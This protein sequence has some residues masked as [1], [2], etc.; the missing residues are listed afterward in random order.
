MLNFL[1]NEILDLFCS[2]EDRAIW[3]T[4]RDMLFRYGCQSEELISS[5]LWKT[6]NRKENNTRKRKP[7]GLNDFNYNRR[8]LCK[9]S[10]IIICFVLTIMSH[11]KEEARK[12]MIKNL[13]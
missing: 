5:D 6:S 3:D 9:S 12:D 8:S 1:T 4:L 13:D 2:Y 11:F 7:K 10:R